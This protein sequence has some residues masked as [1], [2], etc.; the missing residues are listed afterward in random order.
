M[1]TPVQTTVGVGS[2]FNDDD[3]IAG[4][5]IP[6]FGAIAQSQRS[7]GEDLI[8]GEDVVTPHRIGICST[9]MNQPRLQRCK[10]AGKSIKI[11]IED[12]EPRSS[13]VDTDSCVGMLRPPLSDDLRV[14]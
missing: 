7:C 1:L 4:S 2:G 11:D 8:I 6:G 10:I 3:R 14:T 5:D 13:S 12:N 9:A